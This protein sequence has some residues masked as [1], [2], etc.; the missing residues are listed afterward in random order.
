MNKKNYES[1]ISHRKLIYSK[2]FSDQSLA[3][4]FIPFF[5]SGQ[6][7]EVDFGYGTIKRG[8]VG[9]TTGWIPQFIL[10]LR[11]N[12]LGSSYTLSNKDKIT[13]VIN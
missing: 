8:T 4:K 9:I 1:V 11:S 7:I 13:K 2:K 5:E 3:K 10:L 6:R 12:S